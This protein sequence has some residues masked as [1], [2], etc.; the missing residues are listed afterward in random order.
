[1][2]NSFE[3]L[4]IQWIWQRSVWI[5]MIKRYF[6]LPV[7]LGSIESPPVFSSSSLWNE[8]S[9]ST[10]EPKN[11]WD[12]TVALVTDGVLSASSPRTG[13]DR[14][15]G[16]SSLNG[17][18]NPISCACSGEPVLGGGKFGGRLSIINIVDEPTT[19]NANFVFNFQKS[20]I[21]ATNES[22]LDENL[23]FL[24][25]ANHFSLILVA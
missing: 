5:E 18:S 2:T 6:Y 1:M 13:G 25:I 14:Q 3:I 21:F 23:I 19:M 10:F 7:K 22:E 4:S 11:V 9:G 17:A 8:A 15:I 24:S 20:I 12:S 16:V